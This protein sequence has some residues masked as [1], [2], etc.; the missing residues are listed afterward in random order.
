MERDRLVQRLFVVDSLV[1]QPQPITPAAATPMADWVGD[2]TAFYQ[3]TRPDIV[4]ALALTLGD[5]DLAGD[6]GDEAMTRAFQHWHTVANADNPAGWVYRVGLNW[7]TSVLRRRRRGDQP[8]YHRDSVVHTAIVDP[9][10]HLALAEL[11]VKHRSVV[12]CRYLLGWSEADTA[13]A[14]HLRPGTVKSRLHRATAQLKT[15]LEHHRED[16]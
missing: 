7:A 4:R 8:L 3:R 15:R 14:L 11:D 1:A 13:A 10:I 9:D 2:F 16:T 6:A 5:P 12:V